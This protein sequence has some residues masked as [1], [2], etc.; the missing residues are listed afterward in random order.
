MYHDTIMNLDLIIIY[1]FTMYPNTITMYSDLLIIYAFT[2]CPNTIT[3][4]TD[5]IIMYSAIITM[6]QCILRTAIMY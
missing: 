5:T 6:Y 2:M 3:M 1:A 4:Y